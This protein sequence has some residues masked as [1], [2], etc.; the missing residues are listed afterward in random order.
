MVQVP[1]E[2]PSIQKPEALI[3]APSDID[4]SLRDSSAT[5]LKKFMVNAGLDYSWLF[6]PI[7]YKAKIYE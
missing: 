2:G 5:L 4:I 6:G 3:L 7:K 1:L